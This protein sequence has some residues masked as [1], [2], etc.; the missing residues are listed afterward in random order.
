MR[1]WQVHTASQKLASKM[2]TVSLTD[3]LTGLGNRRHLLQDLEQKVLHLQNEAGAATSAFIIYDLNGFKGY[4][5]TFGHP[6]G[7]KLLHKLATRLDE[8]VRGCGHAYRLGGDEFCVLLDTAE[9]LDTIIEATSE[10]LSGRGDSFSIS[11]SYGLVIMPEEGKTAS[12]IM[13]FADQR[14]YAQKSGGRGN[15]GAEMQETLLNTLGERDR[16]LGAH[17][18]E[19]GNLA[20]ATAVKLGLTPERVEE[21]TRAA[22]LHDIGKVGIPDDIL[23]KPGP[24]TDE[25]WVT[26]KLHTVIGER[27]LSG[28]PALAPVGRL[29]RSS[30]ERWDGGGYPDGLAGEDIP[31]GARIVSVADSY[32]AMTADRVYRKGMSADEA[33]KE[34]L[35]CAGGQFD[36]AVVDAFLCAVDEIGTNPSAHFGDG[37]AH[38]DDRARAHAETVTAAE[39]TAT[40]EMP[41]AMPAV[42]KAGGHFVSK[43]IPA[44]R[45]QD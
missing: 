20:T 44:E 38:A 24:L 21:V 43:K 36:P 13:R 7:D 39:A 14:M 34:L 41:A 22:E 2:T 1:M 42:A 31:L 10:A 25:E 12:E 5:D 33:R 27:I 30:H 9:N 3:E 8:A 11:T 37:L 23:F 29:V 6:A 16:D 28:A 26:M 35:K 45:A 32:E 17:N 19:V 15:A 40:D 18:R 4:N